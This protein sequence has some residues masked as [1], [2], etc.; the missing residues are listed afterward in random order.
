M[1]GLAIA[2]LLKQKPTAL[3][4]LLRLHLLVGEWRALPDEDFGRAGAKRQFMERAKLDLREAACVLSK[5]M[6]DDHRRWLK[7]PCTSHATERGSDQL[8]SNREV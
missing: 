5:R 3:R 6:H 1:E 7:Q 4:K 8:L 2:A